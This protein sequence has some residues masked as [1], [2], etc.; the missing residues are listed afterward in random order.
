[1]LYFR[2]LQSQHYDTVYQTALPPLWQH[3]HLKYS[4]QICEGF[5][6]RQLHLIFKTDHGRFAIH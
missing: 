1:M 3:N 6:T 5:L 2:W 4:I